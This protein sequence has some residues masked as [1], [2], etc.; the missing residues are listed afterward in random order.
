MNK[1]RLFYR[2][3]CHLCEVMLDDLHPYLQSD[4]VALERVDIDEHPE[5]LA[6]YNTMVPVLHVNDEPLCKFHLNTE[7]LLQALVSP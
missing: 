5:W 3:G 7:R 1:L 2:E 6:L 4:D